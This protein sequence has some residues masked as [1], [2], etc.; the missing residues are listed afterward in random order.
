MTGVAIMAS[1]ATRRPASDGTT[2]ADWFTWTFPGAPV[3]V[4][5]GFDL[6]SRLQAEIKAL[7]DLEIGGVLIGSARPEQAIVEIH[8]YI[9]ISGGDHPDNGYR[10]APE[11]LERLRQACRVIGYFRTQSEDALRL[12]D[13]ELDMVRTQFPDR[14]NVVL[15]IRTST[16]HNTA[17]IL[18]WG[19]HSFLNVSIMDFPFDAALLLQWE[20]RSSSERPVTDPTVEAQT[21]EPEP[22]IEWEKR[23]DEVPAAIRTVGQP[24]GLIVRVRAAAAGALNQVVAFSSPLPRRAF[25]SA[26]SRM[27]EVLAGRPVV[28]SRLRSWLRRAMALIGTALAVGLTFVRALLSGT[29]TRRAVIVIGLAL[30]LLFIAASLLFTRKLLP[31]EP[32]DRTAERTVSSSIKLQV[33]P[34][35]KG[36][37][38]R[39][40]PQ[41]RLV[42]RAKEGRLVVTR[43]NQKANIEKLNREQL[44]SGHIYYR[45]S[46]EHLNVRLEVE[47]A[48]GSVA[49]EAV[50]LLSPKRAQVSSEG[51]R[52]ETVATV[53]HQPEAAPSSLSQPVQEVAK[54]QP[55]I[56]GGGKKPENPQLLP[57]V[58]Q[59][60]AGTDEQEV[61]ETLGS[62]ALALMSTDDGH[63]IETFVY[64]R[65]P[66]HS[67]TIR[68]KDGRVLSTH[69]A[70]GQ[71]LSPHR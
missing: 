59:I 15:L 39:W 67:L 7:S 33:E 55:Q 63:V 61:I 40:D 25:A 53:Q 44:A 47:D 69:S 43:G 22:P 23:E 16:A 18:F 60:R 42:T 34:Q 1:H 21:A 27:G 68:F 5:I 56:S 14:S 8:D 64:M 54:P 36:L 9:R 52:S 62:P 20:G 6:V 13:D 30:P 32:G 19:Q 50:V 71:V 4:K 35:R 65:N 70:G 66:G 31:R 45:S 26:S 29:R 2:Q 38:I 11:E 46:P 12:R 17:G 37:T 57:S 49:S 51:H 3:C 10:L 48:S 58:D 24:Q 28:V 41:S